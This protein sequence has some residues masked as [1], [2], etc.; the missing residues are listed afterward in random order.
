MASTIK[1]LAVRGAD[2][3]HG[4]QRIEHAGASLAVD[5][6]HMR[7]AGVGLELRVQRR[8]R[9]RL[10]V[11]EIQHAATAPHQAGQARGALAVG[12]VVE[13]EHM[14]VAR[15]DGSHG[16]LDAEGA[17]ALQRHHHMRVLPVDDVHQALAYTRGDGVEVGVP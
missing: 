8:C 5:H 7:D 10:M 2:V 15:D 6:E 9:H 12:P 3:G 11:A 16:G 1:P 13:H 4:L 17:A 14:T